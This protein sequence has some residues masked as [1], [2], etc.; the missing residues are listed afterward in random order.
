MLNIENYEPKNE[1]NTAHSYVYS[2]ITC[3]DDR[4][5]LH[6]L[7]ELWD[8]GV[9]AGVQSEAV[10]PQVKLHPACVRVKGHLVFGHSDVGHS[11]SLAV[12]LHMPKEREAKQRLTVGRWKRSHTF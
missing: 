6:L 8:G 7:E 9:F 2:S 11:C 12:G 4:H 5:A 1:P 10:Y 3:T